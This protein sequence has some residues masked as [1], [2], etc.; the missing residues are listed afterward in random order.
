MNSRFD[1]QPDICKDYKE[2]GFCGYGDSCKFMHDRGDYKAGW[3]IDKDWDAEQEKKKSEELALAKAL[4]IGPLDGTDVQEIE[5]DKDADLATACPICH[6]NFVDPVTTKCGHFFCESC[7]LKQF[8]KSPKCFVCSSATLG[9]FN[10]AKD[11]KARLAKRQARLE[12]VERVAREA[13]EKLQKEQDD[14]QGNESE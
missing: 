14:R 2:T 12:E 3:Q 13:A 4:E 10:A 5:V 8:S 9:V 7:A 6:R 1:Y 11:L